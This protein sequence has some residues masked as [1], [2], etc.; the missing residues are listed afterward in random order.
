MCT[1]IRTCNRLAGLGERYRERTKFGTRLVLYTRARATYCLLVVNFCSDF[2][3]LPNKLTPTPRALDDSCT[4]HIT[5]SIWA[6]S[7][8]AMPSGSLQ[9][10]LTADAELFPSSFPIV[11]S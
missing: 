4:C 2:F 7:L 9:V 8:L 3:T 1:V 5:A 11:V 6:P 10:E